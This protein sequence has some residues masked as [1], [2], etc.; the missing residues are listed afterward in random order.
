[1]LLVILTFIIGSILL[2]LF[3]IN[4]KTNIYNP[5]GENIVQTA[6]IEISQTLFDKTQISEF[7]RSLTDYFDIRSK[8]LNN[9]NTQKE[10]TKSLTTKSKE[11]SSSVCSNLSQNQENTMTSTMTTNKNLE[12]QNKILLNKLNDNNNATIPNGNNSE[13]EKITTNKTDKPSLE[14]SL[15]ETL[16]LDPAT[17]AAEEHRLSLLKK[18]HD[19]SKNNK[20]SIS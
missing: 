4:R 3:S 10:T 16:Q 6:S 2:Y 12:N 15:N 5:Q 17:K 9:P 14:W 7:T 18:R 20:K 1:M 8:T 13:V 11:L 19:K